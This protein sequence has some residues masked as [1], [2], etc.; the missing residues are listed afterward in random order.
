MGELKEGRCCFKAV[1]PVGLEEGDYFSVIVDKANLHMTLELKDE[2]IACASK[3]SNVRFKT[4]LTAN[5]EES[6][7]F[8]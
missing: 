7:E 5:R 4:I 1:T 2:L 8:E 6:E 3:I